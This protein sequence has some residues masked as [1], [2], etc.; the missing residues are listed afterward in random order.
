MQRTYRYLM[1]AVTAAALAACGGGDPDASGRESPLAKR[2]QKME[3]RIQNLAAPIGAGT[4]K[5]DSRLARARG[6][7]QVWVSLEQ[8]S[9]ASFKA[10]QLEAQGMEM[11]SRGLAAP[12]VARVVEPADASLKARVRSHRDELRDKQ[13][14]LMSQLR[15]MGAT[16]LGRVQ[17]AHNAVAV[18]VDAASLA[19]IARLPGVARV[20]PVVHYELDLSETVP[21]VGG[22]LVQASGRTGKGVRVA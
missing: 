10:N 9:V 8:S 17:V 2:T 6:T 22:A 7:V 14:A 3:S 13:D 4:S 18:T 12:S 20:R 11:Q 15:G 5:V 19:S 16:E 21:Y 1:L